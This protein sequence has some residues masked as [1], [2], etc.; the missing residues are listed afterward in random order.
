MSRELLLVALLGLIPAPA[1]GQDLPPPASRPIDYEKDVRPIFAK[2]CVKC[3]GEKVAKGGLVLDQKADALR[4][5]TTARR[6]SPGQSDDSRLIRYVAGVDDTVMPPENAGKPLT[7]EQ[8]G[9]SAPGSTRAP[10]GPTT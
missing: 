8:V 3:H 7:P 6:S 9:S 2:S 10:N 1:R 4:A 5:A